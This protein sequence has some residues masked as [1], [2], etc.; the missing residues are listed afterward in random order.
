MA[1]KDSHQ[2]LGVDVEIGTNTTTKR[3]IPLVPTLIGLLAAMNVASVV[4][5]LMS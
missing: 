1:F 2:G 4:F 3:S 5:V